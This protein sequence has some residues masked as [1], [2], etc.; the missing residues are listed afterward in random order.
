MKYNELE[1]NTFIEPVEQLPHDTGKIFIDINTD[2]AWDRTSAKVIAR[3]LTYD[4]DILAGRVKTTPESPIDYVA[5]EDIYIGT[6]YYYD[7]S[8][9]NLYKYIEDRTINVW[10][11]LPYG[12]VGVNEDPENLVTELSSFDDRLYYYDNTAENPVLKKYSKVTREWSIIAPL[13]IIE[14]DPYTEYD[15]II[16]DILAD[17]LYY[18]ITA[19]KIYQFNYKEY[20]V[21][22]EYTGSINPAVYDFYQEMYKG[23]I[24]INSSVRTNMDE[25]YVCW[26]HPEDKIV[27]PEKSRVYYDGLNNRYYLYDGVIYLELKQDAKLIPFGIFY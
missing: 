24:D 6:H 9:L 22:I 17:N 18:N 15:Y 12:V 10:E 20:W 3:D 26:G 4:L 2:S 1:V 11:E 23:Y 7:L 13:T 16:E 27:H 21:S 8:T 5:F 19:N 25:V 14:V